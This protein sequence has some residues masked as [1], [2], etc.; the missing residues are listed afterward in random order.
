MHGL[1]RR[2]AP[3]VNELMTSLGLQAWK[4]MI[5]AL[6]LPPVPMI[7]LVLAGARLMLRRRLLAWLLV[8]AGCA[9]LWLTATPALGK[10]MR[11]WVHPPP[12]ALSAQRIE[13]LRRERDR[14]PPT[15]IVVL[16]GG[17]VELAVEYGMSNL[18]PISLERL[19][20]GLWLARETR[21]PVA[22]VGGV[23]HGG[24]PGASEAEIAARI[25]ER[26]FGRRLEWT[27][28]RSRDTVENARYAVPLL[29]AAGIRRILLVSHD[30]HLPRAERAF[31]RAA[32]HAGV[33]LEIVPAPLGVVPAYE[34]SW[35]DWVPGRSGQL[36]SQLMLHEWLGYLLGA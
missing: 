16:G 19:R 28:D 2:P 9:G 5:A 23:G 12:P 14:A 36:D 6:L 32:V 35:Q 11:Q 33:P 20:F 3:P 21:L 30:Y 4:P 1:S 26:E 15:A 31:A 22:F 18:T 7:V 29:Q 24:R 10:L 17:R 25:A 13:A 27:E 8:L 34:W